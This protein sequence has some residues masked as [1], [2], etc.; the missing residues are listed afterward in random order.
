[1][2]LKYVAIGA[3]LLAGG[4]LLY[5]ALS[6]S[7]EPPIRVKGGSMYLEL[8]T[9]DGTV[10]WEAAG[11]SWNVKS[12]EK[13]WFHSY[14]FRITMSGGQC[15]SQTPPSEVRSARIEYPTEDVKIGTKLNFKSAA[16]T[17]GNLRKESAKCLSLRTQ[18]SVTKVSVKPW[19]MGREWH[20][21]FQPGQFKELCLY[22]KN[23][24]DSQAY[25]SE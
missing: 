16:D 8:A 6:V 17:N 11:N 10:E 25:C 5:L 13:N 4:Y 24:C 14:N 23:D 12:N 1:M 18:D 9:S 15:S 22:G 21:T 7:D 20:C 2:K 19:P 3:G